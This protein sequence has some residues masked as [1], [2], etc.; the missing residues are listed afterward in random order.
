MEDEPINFNPPALEDLINVNFDFLGARSEFDLCIRPFVS[1]IFDRDCPVVAFANFIANQT[2]I[3]T[4]LVTDSNERPEDSVI[5][6]ITL[7]PMIPIP[8][9]SYSSIYIG[10]KGDLSLLNS[11]NS[12]LLICE[13]VLNMPTELIPHL[14]NQLVLDLEWAE[15]NCEGKFKFDYIVSLSKCLSTIPQSGSARKKRKTV[16][17]DNLLFFRLEDEILL[18]YAEESFLFESEA[19]RGLG[20]A[21]SNYAED[22]SSHKLV[23]ILAKNRYLQAVQ[24][25][26]KTYST[27][28]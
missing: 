8:P 24:E 12:A 11:H 23:M 16:V 26:N 19:S 10:A 13:R 5:G 14:H 20:G 22:N 6:F 2:E 17:P 21:T 28:S 7:V 1:V 3:G 4:F 27:G 18:K 25:I 15:E 9:L